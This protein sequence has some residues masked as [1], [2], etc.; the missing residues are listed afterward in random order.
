MDSPEY[1]EKLKPFQEGIPNSIAEKKE[2]YLLPLRDL[3]SGKRKFDEQGTVKRF[4][5]LL[6]L[7]TLFRHFIERKAAKDP[8]FREVLDTIDNVNG[9][10]N[11]KGKKHTD[12][13]RR[14]T[15]K[16]EDAELM[17]DEEEEE[18]ELA[19]VDFQFRESPAY[20]N[21]QLRPYQIQGLNWL[22]ALHKNQ[23]AGILADEMGL[24]KTLQTIA[25][26][27]YLRYIEKKNGPFLV[28][29]PKS[30]LNNWLREINR[31]TP[32]VS[33]FILQGD[34]E[35]RSKLCHDKLLACDF[36]ICVA[37]YEIIIREKASFK[38][39]DWEYVVI[40]EAHRIKNEE[41]MLSQVLR[42]FS[43]RNRLLIT[44]TPLQNNLHELWALLN[45]LLPDIFADSATFDEWFSSESSEEDKEKVVKQLHTVLSPFLLRRIK[46]DVE[47]SLLPKKELNVYVGMSSMQKKWYKQILEKDIDAVNGSNGQKESKTRLLNI[48]MQLRKCCNHPYLFDGAE[49][50]PPYTTDEHLV[51][52]SAKLKVLDK[53]LKK[54]KEQGSRVLIFSQMSRV[55]DIL[56]DYCYFREYEYCR[57]DGSTAHEDRINAIDDYNAP[58]SKK[59][60]FLLTTRAGGLGINLTTADIVVLY[61]S[62]WN[63]QA[64][65]QAM[66][67]AHRIGQKKQV[68][69]FRFVTDN[70]VE[71]KILER[72]T[73]K[74]KLDQLVIQQ[75]R[76]TNKKKENKNDS[77]EGLLS[78]IQHGAVDVFKSNDSSAMTS[79]T[80]TPH[81][82]DGKD[83]DEDVDLDAL[84]AQSEDKTRSL[85]AKYATLGLDEL[86][87]FNQD[88]A[89]EW[90]GQN[91]KKKVE[92]DII[93]P[94][95]IPPTK[96]E[97]STNANYSVDNYY[98]DVLNPGRN[99]QYTV[100]PKMP[101]L[102]PLNSH[103]LLRPQLKAIYEK[104]R[105]WIAK[106]NNYVPNLDDVVTTYGDVKDEAEKKDKLELLK[107]SIANAEPL[108]EE[109]TNNKIEWEK[110]GFHNW[111][112][113]DFRK[114]ITASGKHGRNSIQAIAA[115]F[116]GSKTEEEVRAY[117]KAF[118]ANLE[119]VE[120]Y[121][122]YVKNIET[123]EER[124]R[125]VKMNQEALRRKISQ[126]ANPLFELKLKFPP[127]TNNK[128][129]FSEE[130]DRFI[131]LMLFKYG[132][133][134][135]NVYEMIRD[136]IK[137]HP[138]FELDFFF[139]SRTPIELQRRTITLLQC[140]EKEFNT[141]IQKTDELN[142]RLKKED[143]EGERLREK[144]KEENKAR[145]Q[146]EEEQEEE[147]EEKEEEVN[148][149]ATQRKDE[150][151]EVDTEVNGNSLNEPEQKKVKT[152]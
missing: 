85:N 52:N 79:Q 68:R 126:C 101:K 12:A 71:E 29:A 137:H 4:E 27:G 26:L 31:W 34:K 81:P 127:S 90:D 1:L 70:S 117:A 20:V 78:M 97:R 38:K 130:E 67:R 103:Q 121:E 9:K 107:L 105:M 129:T 95:F 114:F 21:G 72:A 55:L 142:D 87:R 35:E 124:V 102:Q 135:E 57:I 23:L 92:K 3:A 64:D 50:G 44:G 10:A 91:F 77:K 122:R 134:R 112:K 25:F 24:G 98:K 61:D 110:E 88:S 42:E 2:R 51:Y 39:I 89:Y 140:L 82:D 143:E 76:V 33:A 108:T 8:R 58:D 149:T 139:Q 150:A 83:K 11:G 75:G 138:L 116:G 123:E 147:E 59:F 41:S 40:D 56:E 119:R 13:R 106:K 99:N 120:D 146:E 96:R 109:E 74:L 48:V 15:E 5:H 100:P 151:T 60:I 16:E 30:T 46:N 49:P 28:I 111:N 118:W 63:P 132:L 104:E 73:Q 7:S 32:E 131:L 148:G 84:L 18:E 54:F 136:E 36:D 69:V 86:Q 45:F 80:G 14:K 6:G 37:S 43:S 125:R 22:V 17:K 133:D 145:R 93:N 128:R 141:G 47:G 113:L 62:D 19:D 152:E 115:E 66:D 144:L 53:L 65:L 94:L